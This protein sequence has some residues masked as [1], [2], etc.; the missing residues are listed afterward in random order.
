MEVILRCPDTWEGFLLILNPKLPCC[1]TFQL[2][3][4]VAKRIARCGCGATHCACAR[5][6]HRRR[7]AGRRRRRAGRGW[8]S[9]CPEVRSRLGQRAVRGKEGHE[10]Q[11]GLEGRSSDQLGEGAWVFVFVEVQVSSL[12]EAAAS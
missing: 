1:P 3:K 5:G 8:G 7:R 11:S 9:G 6:D 2:V 4:E 10:H 12:Q